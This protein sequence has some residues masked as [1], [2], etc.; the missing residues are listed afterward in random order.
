MNKN[1]YQSKFK[2]KKIKTRLD[3][4][5]MKQ[6]FLNLIINAIEAI[7]NKGQILISARKEK[8]E[9]VGHN[10]IVIEIKDNGIGIPQCDIGKIFD[11]FFS[12]KAVGTGLGLAVSHK[13]VQDH[14]GRIEVESIEHKETTFYINLPMNK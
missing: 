1:F 10:W 5:R 12:T 8:S 7:E 14:G 6:V 11:P 9:K 2:N 4:D 13:I 3:P